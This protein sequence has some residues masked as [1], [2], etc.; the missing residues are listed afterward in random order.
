MSPVMII[1]ELAVGWSIPHGDVFK[2]L[3]TC[4][5]AMHRAHP[6]SS[7]S[8]QSLRHHGAWRL[9]AGGREHLVYVFAP[10][11]ES[12]IWSVLVTPLEDHKDSWQARTYL[13][14]LMNAG[15]LL[16]HYSDLSTDELQFVAMSHGIVAPPEST[17]TAFP[18]P[19]CEGDP[20]VCEL[21]RDV[22]C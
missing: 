18:E 21:I 4:R 13:R 11:P 16:D 3:A 9:I 1:P 14:F 5:V 7:C 6:S 22:P 8:L 20:C 12:A 17:F 2:V 10:S 15:A 19:I